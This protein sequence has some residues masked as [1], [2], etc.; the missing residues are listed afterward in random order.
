M[1]VRAALTQRRVHLDELLCRYVWLLLDGDLAAV[2]KGHLHEHYHGDT[3]TVGTREM[4][5][6]VGAQARA[7]AQPR[8]VVGVWLQLQKAV[9]GVEDVLAVLTTIRD[10]EVT[11]Y[12]GVSDRDVTDFLWHHGWGRRVFETLFV[13]G[14]QRENR[15]VAGWTAIINQLDVDAYRARLNAALRSRTRR[16]GGYPQARAVGNGRDTARQ[17]AAADRRAARR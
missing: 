12:P 16:E 11:M 14:V 5:D 13:S 4:W 15:D 9:R 6:I 3:V 10:W 2:I 7:N 1:D 8:D 17:A